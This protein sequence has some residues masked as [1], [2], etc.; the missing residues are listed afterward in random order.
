[1]AVALALLVVPFAHAGGNVQDLVYGYWMSKKKDVVVHLE[2]CPVEEQDKVAE[3]CGSIHWLAEGEELFDIHNP[4]RDM[5]TQPL[6]GSK[7]LWGM[8]QDKDIPLR[9]SGGRVYKPSKGKTYKAYMEYSTE[10]GDLSEVLKLHGYVG[11]PTL[12]KTSTFNRV[13]PVDYARCD[14]LTDVYNSSETIDREEVE[15]D[16]KTIVPYS[17]ND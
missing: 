14:L 16:N 8:T 17:I 6:C 2:L 13:D 12:G 7:V 9:W 10:E 5:T 15:L 1:M 11:V 4:E 3:L